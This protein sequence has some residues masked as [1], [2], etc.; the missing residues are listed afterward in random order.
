MKLKDFIIIALL[1]VIIIMLGFQ[2]GWRGGGGKDSIFVGSEKIYDSARYFFPVLQPAVIDSFPME[3][4]ADVDTSAILRMYFTEKHYADT[5][6]DS[7]LVA[8]WNAK[9]FMNSM[10]DF[11]LDYKILRPK[12]EKK[13]LLTK[14]RVFVGPVAGIDQSG[15]FYLGPQALLLTKKDNCFTADVDLL[16]RGVRAGALWKISFNK[17][18]SVNR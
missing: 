17:N 6:R 7:N 13:Y 10:S 12:E 4:P 18:L 9:V 2:S 14:T 8:S 5:L 3:V 1:V 11:K 15:R 16:N